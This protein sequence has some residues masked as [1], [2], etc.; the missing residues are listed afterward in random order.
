MIDQL[1]RKREWIQGEERKREEVGGGEGGWVWN[2]VGSY[3][4]NRR[5]EVS[6]DLKAVIVE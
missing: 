3:E 1:K 4:S 6:E 5:D 2:E